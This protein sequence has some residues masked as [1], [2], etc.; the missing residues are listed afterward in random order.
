MVERSANSANSLR[1]IHR[2]HHCYQVP[3]QHYHLPLPSSNSHQH[4]ACS[5]LRLEASEADVKQ[6]YSQINFY[7]RQTK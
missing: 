7:R 4:L 2:T 3:H 5:V 1:H 6:Q